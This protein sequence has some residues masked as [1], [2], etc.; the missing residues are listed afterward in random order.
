MSAYDRQ[1]QQIEDA[2]AA[3]I[4]GMNLII[5]VQVSNHLFS[6]GSDS[7][8][9]NGSF[10]GFGNDEFLRRLIEAVKHEPA[11]YNPNHE[12]YGNKHSSAQYKVLT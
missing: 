2:I 1:Q 11:L 12:H 7:P 5:K 9:R 8:E 10:N 4:S 3:A 6:G